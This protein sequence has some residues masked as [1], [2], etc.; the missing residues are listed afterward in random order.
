MFYL[1]LSNKFPVVS[2]ITQ[3]LIDMATIEDDFRKVL[4]DFKKKLKPEEQAEFKITTL[5]ELEKVA[6]EVQ[7]TQRKSKTA[8]NLKKIEPFLQAMSQYTRI[9]EVFLNA[10]SF[11]C[12]V[13]GPM[14]SMLLVSLPLS[15]YYRYLTVSGRSQ[16]EQ[17]V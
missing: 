16:L 4:T 1:I 17:G 12:F 9:I 13:W 10:S 2:G 8:R 5:A 3:Q 15:C 7:E 11:L 6:Y 14:K